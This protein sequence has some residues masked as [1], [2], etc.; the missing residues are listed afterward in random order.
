L[1]LRR[2]SRGQQAEQEQASAVATGELRFA[3]NL[4]EKLIAYMDRATINMKLL[5]PSTTFS[6]RCSFKMPSRDIKFFSKVILYLALDSKIE[7]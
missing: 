4:L 3:Y 2:P 7:L 6:R 1:L 5:K